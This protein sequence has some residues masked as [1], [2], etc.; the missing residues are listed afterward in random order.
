MINVV[1]NVEIFIAYSEEKD[2]TLCCDL[3]E[4]SDN[5]RLNFTQVCFALTFT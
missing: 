3:I 5:G 1:F 2:S 4:I